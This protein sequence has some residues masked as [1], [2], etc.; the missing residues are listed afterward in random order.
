MLRNDG[1]AEIGRAFVIA[2]PAIALPFVIRAAVI[3][4]VATGNGKVSTIGIAYSVLAGLSIHRT[5]DSAA[6]LPNVVETAALS[7]FDSS[8]SFGAAKSTPVAH[9]IWIFPRSCQRHDRASWGGF[10][11]SCWFRWP[12]SSCWEA[13]SKAF[14]VQASRRP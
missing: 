7:R 10:R 11:H 1:R 13:F 12:L 4:G 14:R 9:G 6:H 5:F 8:S 2:L 3:E